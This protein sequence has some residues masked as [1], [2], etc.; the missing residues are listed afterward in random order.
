M[1][2]S[3]W[4]GLLEVVL[5]WLMV[6]VCMTLSSEAPA[7]T[8]FRGDALHSGL[9]SGPAPSVAAGA[10]PRVKWRFATGDRIAGSAVMHDGVL[11]FGSDDGHVYALDAATGGQR[12]KHR[13]GGPVPSTPAVAHGRV[14]VASYDGR[15][16]ALDAATGELVWRF[17]TAGERRFEAKGLHGMLPKAQTFP[18]PFDVYLSSPTVVDGVVYIG[19]GDGHVYALDAADGSLRWKFD[20]GEVVHASPAVARVGAT[21][22]DALVVVGSWNSRL[23]ALEAKT[24]A[25]RWRFQAGVDPV[26]FNQQGFQSSPTI[27]L[28]GRGGG[29]VYVGGRDSHVYALDLASG[30][31]RWRFSTGFSWVIGTPLVH[32]GRVYFATSDTAL[33]HAVDAATGKPLW[34]QQ[35]E[36]YFFGSPVLAGHTL[37][38]GSL[39]GS[40]MARD[41]ASGVLLWRW[42]TQASRENVGW[43]LTSQGAFNSVWLFPSPWRERTAVGSERQWSVGSIM[44][45]P[46]VDGGVVYVGS[47]DGHFYALH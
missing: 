16:R 43:V 46:L 45:T 23:F 13:T 19:S 15:I 18:D 42:R 40:L 39:N 17:A 33:V 10:E 11:F 12:W 5:P 34:Q 20:T 21:G 3:R 22:N 44:A 29:T 1:M 27:A 41:A 32:G 26:M 36:A 2:P 7:Q 35:D 28:D 8:M 4:D 9:A 14:Y 24:G 31:E 6:V 37:L 38:I 30:A 25:E 47:A